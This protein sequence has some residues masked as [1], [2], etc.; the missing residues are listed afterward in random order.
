MYVEATR[1]Y[2]AGSK[3]ESHG[4]GSSKKLFFLGIIPIIPKF[5][6]NLNSFS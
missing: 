2:L 6:Q 3:L 1:Q 4:K 5:G